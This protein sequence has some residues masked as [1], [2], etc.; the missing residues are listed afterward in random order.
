M[1]TICSDFASSN[2]PVSNASPSH[3]S[4]FLMDDV[5]SVMNG[6]MVKLADLERAHGYVLQACNERAQALAYEKRVCAYNTKTES[7]VQNAAV[8]RW[9]GV[10]DIACGALNVLGAGTLNSF[11]MSG[12]TGFSKIG[13]GISKSVLTGESAEA[14]KI[15][16]LAEFHTT[17]A[18][19]TD[20]RLED[21]DRKIG[22][23]RQKTR[24]AL[25]MLADLNGRLMASVKFS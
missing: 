2:V 17:T 15:N 8:E 11:A 13:E 18:Q 1:V 22:E 4:K 24:E 21:T 7:I 16:L 19:E 9:R 12:A 25:N 3:I 10:T 6:L 14:Q 20:K 5:I 23:M